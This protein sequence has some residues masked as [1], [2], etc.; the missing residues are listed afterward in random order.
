MKPEEQAPIMKSFAQEPTNEM[1]AQSVP[2]PL[3]LE[4]IITNQFEALHKHREAAIASMDVE[5]IHKLR[6][7]TRKLQ[8]SLDLLQFGETLA[9]VKRSKR[10]LRN[11]RRKLSEVR[12]LDVFLSLLEQEAASCKALHHPFASLRKELQRRR[13]KRAIK[14][15]TFLE[16]VSLKGL[17]KPLGLKPVEAETGKQLE[18]DAAEPAG[19]HFAQHLDNPAILQRTANRLDQRHQEFQM[20]AAQALPTTHPE[21]L[22]QLRIAAKRL[23]YLLEIASEMGYGKSLAVLNWLRSLQDKIGDW[24]DLEAIEYEIICITARKQFMKQ[25]LEEAS[26]IL[27]AAVHLQK[28]KRSLVKHLFPVKIHRRL[29]STA[30]RVAKTLRQ[31]SQS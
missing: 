7:T 4:Q 22:H 15:R 29:E 5:A 3:T 11:L 30:N 28:K 25:H 31:A 24:H 2:L 23:R 1:N 18:K 20:L 8:A 19:F 12:N 17:A 13:D 9:V 26:A 10:S 21:E 27:S 14:V 16:S 6:V